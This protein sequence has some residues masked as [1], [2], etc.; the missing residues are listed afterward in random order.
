MIRGLK[1][2]STLVVINLCLVFVLSFMGWSTYESISPQT[3]GTAGR[4]YFLMT[5]ASCLVIL[6]RVFKR[7]VYVHNQDKV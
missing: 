4:F 6:F 3:W 5:N 7:G 2:A 1:I